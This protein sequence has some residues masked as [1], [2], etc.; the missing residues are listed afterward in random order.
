MDCLQVRG[1]RGYGYVGVLPEEQVLGQWYEVDLTLWLDLAAAGQSD[2]LEETHDYS[3][4]ITQIQTLIQQTR[5]KLVESLAEAIAAMVLRSPRIQ[6]VQVRVTK[7]PPVPNFDGSIAV[8]IIRPQP[9]PQAA[10]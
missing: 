5:V 2:R 10:P 8:E 7:H 6:Q 1:I 3:A 9:V 4:T